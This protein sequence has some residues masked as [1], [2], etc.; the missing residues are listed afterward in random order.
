MGVIV[1]YR[2][3]TVHV[4]DEESESSVM[5]GLRGNMNRGIR[6]EELK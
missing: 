6:T 1:K 3:R 4:D 5:D 2:Q